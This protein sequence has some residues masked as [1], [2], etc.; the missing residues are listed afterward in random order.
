VVEDDPSKTN[1]VIGYVPDQPQLYEKLTGRE[2]LQF[3]GQMYGLDGDGLRQAIETQ[4]TQ[5]RLAD[6][7]DQLT[8]SYSYGM[9][10]RT[11]FA[12]ALL[13]APQVIVVDEPLVGLDPHTIRMVKDLLQT[14]AKRGAAVL[15]STHTLA[16]AEEVADRIGI[17]DR[18]RLLFQGTL[19]ELRQE[20]QDGEANLEDLYLRLVERT[21]A[22]RSGAE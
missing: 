6:F 5:F 3:V 4:I 20:M 19:A 17:I 16:V 12:A 22:G 11:V 9:K 21:E 13:H 8:E 15:I 2:F 1:C 10:Q 7:I 18:G 14:C